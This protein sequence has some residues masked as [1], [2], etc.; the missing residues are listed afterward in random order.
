MILLGWNK[1][2]VIIHESLFTLSSFWSRRSP[3]KISVKLEGIGHWDG[4]EAGPRH[5][6]WLFAHGYAAAVA[7]REMC[8]HSKPPRRPPAFTQQMQWSGL[9]EWNERMKP[10]FLFSMSVWQS[11]VLTKKH[12]KIVYFVTHLRALNI[13]FNKLH[14][15]LSCSEDCGGKTNR[16]TWKCGFV[17]TPKKSLFFYNYEPIATYGNPEA[18]PPLCPFLCVV[19]QV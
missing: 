18:I 17:S 1:A 6:C 3:C 14:T 9:V 12:S 10:L 11:P 8:F 7:G 4:G 16:P 2:M 5:I 15:A 19:F 13:S